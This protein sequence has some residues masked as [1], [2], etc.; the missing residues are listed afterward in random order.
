MPA[1]LTIYKRVQPFRQEQMEYDSIQCANCLSQWRL[2]HWLC[3]ECWEPLHARAVNDMLPRF[4]SWEVDGEL[5]RRYGIGK[6]DF[7]V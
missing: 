5:R 4:E 2:G 6:R 1:G 3:M 7:D